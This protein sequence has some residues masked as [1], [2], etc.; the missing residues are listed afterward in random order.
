MRKT[1]YLF[2]RKNV[3]YFRYRV[4]LSGQNLFGSRKII[5]SLK[6]LSS[7]ISSSKV[8]GKLQVL[9]AQF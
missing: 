4:S 3:F 9:S 7:D 8:C 1:A 2:G 5:Q 6:P